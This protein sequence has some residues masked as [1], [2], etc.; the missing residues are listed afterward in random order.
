L[1]PLCDRQISNLD[2]Q[3][4]FTFYGLQFSRKWEVRSLLIFLSLQGIQITHL[5]AR[6]LSTFAVPFYSGDPASRRWLT[7]APQ[8]HVIN[9]NSW[10]FDD[11]H[12]I[13]ALS[14]QLPRC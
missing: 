2:L 9:N 7:S 5:Q 6:S 11:I 8:Q 1:K 4:E 12:R 13:L 14:P 10:Q 3:P